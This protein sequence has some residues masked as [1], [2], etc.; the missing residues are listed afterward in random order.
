MKIPPDVLEESLL[1]WGGK[2]LRLFLC[3]FFLHVSFADMSRVSPVFSVI[4][5]QEVLSISQNRVFLLRQI[6]P[7][8]LEKE[9]KRVKQREKPRECAD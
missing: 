5:V 1:N 7:Q 3:P 4:A 8:W 2:Y 9:N 6:I